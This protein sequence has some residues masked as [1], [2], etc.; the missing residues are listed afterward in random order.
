MKEESWSPGDGRAGCSGSSIAANH[1]GRS[2][3]RRRR[4]RASQEEGLNHQLH[5][6]GPTPPDSHCCWQEAGVC[7]P[8]QHYSLAPPP[9][10]S[11]G[12]LNCH[13]SN[14]LLVSS[15]PSCT[16][17]HTNTVS[18][19]N[20]HDSQLS[21]SPSLVAATSSK[22]P[23][24]LTTSSISSHTHSSSSHHFSL[25][26]L[27][28][29]P[30]VQVIA[31]PLCCVFFST[32]L[33]VFLHTHIT[34]ASTLAATPLPSHMEGFLHPLGGPATGVYRCSSEKLSRQFPLPSFVSKPVGLLLGN[35]GPQRTVVGGEI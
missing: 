3:R 23:S 12:H 7:L 29:R 25:S 6:K 8:G 32:F 33:S 22:F 1:R 24:L 15:D 27:Q 2:R 26:M 34:Q 13:T 11:L 18:P 21:S 20:L 14:Y 31:P 16:V 9:P 19:I 17:T 4:L 10:A 30:P 5:K 35:V 28:L